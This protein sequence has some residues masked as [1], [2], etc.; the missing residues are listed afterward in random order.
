MKRGLGSV[1]P[2]LKGD[3]R[4]GVVG[5]HILPNIIKRILPSLY[6]PVVVAIIIVIGTN[7]VIEI[8]VIVIVL[9]AINININPLDNC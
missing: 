2:V 8:I 3:T 6:L 9:L 4:A 5:G 1:T 7:S